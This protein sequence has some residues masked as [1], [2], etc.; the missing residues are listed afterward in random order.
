MIDDI[1][2]AEL[3]YRDRTDESSLDE[4]ELLELLDSYLPSLVYS[5]DSQVPPPRERGG[6]LALEKEFYEWRDTTGDPEARRAAVIRSF[7]AAE[8]ERRG[9]FRLSRSQESRIAAHLDAA[10]E[11]FLALQL[12]HHAA[13]TFQI[14]ADLH[15]WLRQRSRSELSLLNVRRAQHLTRPH[16]LRRF[17]EKIYDMTCGYGHRPFRMLGWMAALLTVFSTAVWLSGSAGYA[18]SLHACLINFLNPVSLADMDGSFNGPAQVL[19]IIESYFGTL[20]LAI[21]FAFLVRG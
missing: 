2:K 18:T 6:G 5:F 1:A 3:R 14:A 8:T 10:G 11:E 20:S 19:L 9:Q 21:F 4:D 15:L 12:P 13:R 7:L 17:L 16:G